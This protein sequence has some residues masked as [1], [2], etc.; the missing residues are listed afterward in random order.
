MRKEST[1]LPVVAIALASCLALAGCETAAPG[2]YGGYPANTYP[3]DHVISGTEGTMLRT[4][5]TAYP[6]GAVVRMRLTNRTGRVAQYNLCRSRIEAV[7]SDGDWRVVA[8]ALADACT[9]ELRTLAPGAS[10]AYQL[11]HEVLQRRGNYRIRTRLEDTAGRTYVDAVSNT[12]QIRRD[13]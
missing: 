2:S 3:P 12:F 1:P 11:K 5:A 7:T 13:D 4:D 6:G 10:V 8:P 9:M